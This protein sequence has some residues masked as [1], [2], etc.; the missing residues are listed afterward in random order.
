MSCDCI[1]SCQL[2]A[3]AANPACTWGTV[4]GWVL[5]VH[6]VSTGNDRWWQVTGC[7]KSW[8][9]LVLQV[10]D[11]SLCPVNLG[12]CVQIGTCDRTLWRLRQIMIWKEQSWRE[13]DQFGGYSPFCHSPSWWCGGHKDRNRGE[14]EE[15]V[16]LSDWLEEKTTS[17]VMVPLTLGSLWDDQVGILQW[18]HTVEVIWIISD[19]NL[20]W[21]W[22]TGTYT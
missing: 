12:E 8:Q 6:K 20:S 17:P 11:L 16:G 22:I 2:L 14:E 5:L 21:G 1:K 18:I 3:E 4:V 7:V 13:G 10:R 15:S 19:I 9:G